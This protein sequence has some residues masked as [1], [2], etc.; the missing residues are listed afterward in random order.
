MSVDT[1]RG[2]VT[3]TGAVDNEQQKVRAGE[4]ARSVDGVKKVNN[5]LN[6][7]KK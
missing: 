6:L 5:L 4:L 7:K 3:L 2:Y 1:Y